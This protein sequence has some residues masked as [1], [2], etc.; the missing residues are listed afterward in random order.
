MRWII[1]QIKIVPEIPDATP[2]L[3]EIK[4]YQD[5]GE[6]EGYTEPEWP[7]PAWTYDFTATTKKLVVVANSKV[8]YE[9]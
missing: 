6:S 1:Q 5:L 3:P 7:F 9:D 8:Y 4:L 2:A